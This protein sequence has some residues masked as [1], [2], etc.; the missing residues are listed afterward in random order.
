VSEF[1]LQRAVVEAA[2]LFGWLVAHFRPARTARGWRTPVAADGA[3]FP[4]LV[5]VKPGRLVFA[6]L[7]AATGRLS[8]EQ[9]RWLAAL[10]LS[11][12][13]EVYV[14]RPADWLDGTIEARL[15]G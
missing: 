12:R 9:A 5:L 3:G 10:G 7:K 14:W 1:E 2:R 8:D 13:C 15:R 4:D 6:E 11:E